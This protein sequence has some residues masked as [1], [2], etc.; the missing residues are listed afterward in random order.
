MLPE[1]YALPCRGSSLATHASG[2]TPISI[3]KRHKAL[4]ASS[5]IAVVGLIVVSW[6]YAA[7][8]LTRAPSSGVPVTP[9]RQQF[10]AHPE[11]WLG[12]ARD[13]STFQQEL[14]AGHVT[15]VGVAEMGQRGTGRLLVTNNRGERYA[16][17]LPAGSGDVQFLLIEAGKQ[18]A[19]ALTPVTIN[20]GSPAD[21]MAGATSNTFEALS[22]ALNLALPLILLLWFARH[23]GQRKANLF[24]E[25]PDLCFGDVIGASEA[26]GALSEVVAFLRQPQKYAAL[27]AR[28]PR[29]VL[30]DGP[31]GTGKTLLAR[32]LAGECGA[33]FI[34]VDG[35]YF[36][37]MFY[38]QGIKRVT[39]LFALA[40]KHAPC[41]IFID[42][43]DGIG[44]RSSGPP[45]STGQGE[46]NRII[47]RLL[48]EMDG[49]KASEDVVIIAAT[50]HRENIDPALIRPGRFD[51]ICRVSMP[52][53]QERCDLFTYYAARIKC[54]DGMDLGL[55]GRASAGSSPADIA[56]IV[57][58]AAIQAAERGA[59]AVTQDD[60]QLALESLQLGGR[61]SSVKSAVT[62][63]TRAR[64]AFHES[65]H[66][67]VAHVAQAGVVG[68]I[69][70]EPRGQAL[71]VT[72]VSREDETPLYGERELNA[73]L[74]MMLAGREA[75]L[76]VYETTT[77]GAADDLKR[78]SQ[79]AMR[80]VTELGFSREF[81]VL[82]F[83][84][85]P[86][87]FMS[88]TTKERALEEARVLLTRAQQTCRAILEQHR[89]ALD[90]LAGE[91]VLNAT[92]SSARFQ[93]LFQASVPEGGR[94]VA[95][96]TR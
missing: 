45:G 89:S 13:F 55:L 86:P 85:I 62:E 95:S 65:G 37:S 41:V 31:P 17:V 4:I 59:P 25:K 32:A 15:E 33:T 68:R 64:V 47:N 94:D 8:F 36:S 66:A 34:S 83:S 35:A 71:G 28:P 57:N 6:P 81:G 80:M 19:F 69:S 93:S 10:E 43:I 1:V 24:P 22:K 23:L 5:L 78:A 2:A 73:Q 58:R 42:E 39:G 87:E 60:L 70:I 74:A 38:E 63:Q 48:V 77:S 44:S 21:R 88:P 49:F 96:L 7:E 91:L 90:G 84:G 20:T 26:K 53:Q 12:G 40:R 61:I 51:Q 27:G 56:M 79:L 3:L 54:E 82:S 92:V 76:L 30:L 72:F 67:L 46:E 50:N 18:H 16:T 14:L 75:E 52:N 9:L 29:G 11:R